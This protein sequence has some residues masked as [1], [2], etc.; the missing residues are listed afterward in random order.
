M[1]EATNEMP[2]SQ[3]TRAARKMSPRATGRAEGC[4]RQ[5]GEAREP[6][7]QD[8]E[9]AADGDAQAQRDI[10]RPGPGRGRDQEAAENEEPGDVGVRDDQG[11]GSWRLPAR[12]EQ[13]A[14]CRC[15][16]WL[17]AKSVSRSNFS[18]ERLRD[19][20]A[21]MGD[22]DSNFTWSNRDP[23]PDGGFLP[24]FRVHPRRSSRRGRRRVPRIFRARRRGLSG[25]QRRGRSLRPGLRS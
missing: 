17:A 16:A 10:D 5:E 8:H 23:S 24:F 12:S 25:G 3:G 7:F 2:I 13:E 14:G 6:G 19:C 18:Q 9:E 22:C 4:L 1:S 15:R 21:L 11:L 20:F